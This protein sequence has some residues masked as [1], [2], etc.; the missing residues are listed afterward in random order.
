MISTASV[1]SG[2]EPHLHSRWFDLTP[3]T[4][5]WISNTQSSCQRDGTE[6]ILTWVS[7]AAV[8]PTINQSRYG[9]KP[10]PENIRS[11][12][13]SLP[14]L[15]TIVVENYAAVAA[16]LNNTMHTDT[17][18]RLVSN[19]RSQVRA[20]WPPNLTTLGPIVGAA[21]FINHA[22]LT[23]REIESSTHKITR[24][25]W[26][27]DSEARFTATTKETKQTKTK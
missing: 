23:H 3:V 7:H 14:T 22:I 15:A 4:M 12:S 9:C 17:Y 1:S 26:I 25:G 13:K 21:D 18:L 11:N 8:Q 19:R 2:I 10:K 27:E 6:V 20:R 24:D 5:M 16:Y